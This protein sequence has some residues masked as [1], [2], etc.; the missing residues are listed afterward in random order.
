M[1]NSRGEIDERGQRRRHKRESRDRV[2]SYICIFFLE[3]LMIK[4]FMVVMNN[5]MF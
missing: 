1:T 5:M 2:H 3:H 4:H